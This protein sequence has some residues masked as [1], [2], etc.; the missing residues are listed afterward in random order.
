M[1]EYIS[2]FEYLLNSNLTKDQKRNEEL[3]FN[4]MPPHV[5]HNLK[6]DIPVVDVLSDNITFLFADICGFTDYSA[7]VEPHQVVQLISELFVDID[8]SCNNC[9]CY[10]V[11]TI[12]DCYVVLGWTGKVPMHERSPIEEARNVVSLARIMV[13]IIERVRDRIKFPGL[14]M[15]IGIHTVT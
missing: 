9:N 2:S 6:E 7:T 5:V 3:L 14:N 11:H 13:E 12:G 4:L 8:A 10:K 15:R 1:R